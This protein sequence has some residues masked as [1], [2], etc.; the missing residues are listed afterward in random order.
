MLLLGEMVTQTFHPILIESWMGSKGHPI[1]GT[2]VSLAGWSS[3]QSAAGGTEKQLVYL[4]AAY[5]LCSSECKWV[6]TWMPVASSSSLHPSGPGVTSWHPLPNSFSGKNHVTGC[7]KAVIGKHSRGS[8]ELPFS[9]CALEK[10]SLKVSW[11]CAPKPPWQL[12]G[13]YHNRQLCFSFAK[14]FQSHSNNKYFLDK[15]GSPFQNK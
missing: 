6:F 4:D 1:L 5:C 12:L 10:I 2:Q 8:T 11:G 13:A 3:G 14:A 9:P 15:K 7:K